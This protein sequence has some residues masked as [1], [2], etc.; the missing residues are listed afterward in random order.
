MSS[1]F[2]ICSPVLVSN[3]AH[4]GE[5]CTGMRLGQDNPDDNSD[6]FVEK[7]QRHGPAGLS[8]S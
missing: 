4:E 6:C 2:N 8:I 3:G 1:H 5:T 7:G